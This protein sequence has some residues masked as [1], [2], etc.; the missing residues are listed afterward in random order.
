MPKL[1]AQRTAVIEAGVD[2][3]DV[4]ED[5][6][7]RKKRDEWILTGRAVEEGDTLVVPLLAALS[8]AKERRTIMRKV[9]RLGVQ[10]EDLK[11]DVVKVKRTGRPAKF[12]PTTEDK[13][14]ICALWQD[15]NVPR[16][17]VLAEAERRLGGEVHISI[18]KRWCGM[19]RAKK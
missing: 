18:I 4:W 2:E 19:A 3:A 9:A 13:A 1:A 5:D 14:A 6:E 10:V 15:K 11:A 7:S 12:Q 17:N 16:A 8:T